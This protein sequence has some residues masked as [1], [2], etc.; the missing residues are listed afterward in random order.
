M[1]QET[2]PTKAEVVRMLEETGAEGVARLRGLPEGVWQQG[3][4]ENG[5]NARQILAHVAS[6]E[7][8]Y[9]RLIDLA[10]QPPEVQPT[11]LQQ[12]TSAAPQQHA[13]GAPQSAQAAG[14]ARMTGGVNSYND[15]QVE[16]RADASLA[17]LIAEFEKNRA[18]TIAA[19]EA[20][21]E[22][23]FDA[24]IRS[25]GGISGTL[26]DVM[27]AIAIEHVRGHVADIVGTKS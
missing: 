21:D 27:N 7:W 25:A 20:A 3:R 22:P 13:A 6:I 10:K 19:V 17:D 14:S 9:P 26:S 16:K 11:S 4:Y 1:A 18:A 8:T 12:A 2:V 15:R 5:W 24:P 23:L